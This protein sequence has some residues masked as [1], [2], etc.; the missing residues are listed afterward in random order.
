MTTC[1]DEC[2]AL[3]P[4]LLASSRAV[5]RRDGLGTLRRP[6]GSLQ[7]TFHGH[8]LYFFAPDLGAGAPPGLTL[9]EYSVDADSSGVWYTVL[10]QGM[11]D[12]GTT[13]VGSE[14]SPAGTILSITAGLE[15]TTATLYAFSR[16]TATTS[17]CTGSCAIIWQPVLTTTPPAATGTASASMLG[18]IRRYDD[19]FQ[20]TYN[21]HPLYFFAKGLNGGTS[22]A[23]KSAAGGTF[24][25]VTAAG[26]VG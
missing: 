26:A 9:G 22:G 21:G 24:H 16:D 2:T 17:K 1:K 20:V 6:D 12:P 15:H 13:K 19:T 25:V 3:W 11:P 10:P 23:G 5:A 7:V 4:P 14:S 18:T 8:P